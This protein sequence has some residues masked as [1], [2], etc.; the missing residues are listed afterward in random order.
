[1]QDSA[2]ERQSA[3]PDL[4]T[5]LMEPE[6]NVPERNAVLL[7]EETAA[8]G[9]QEGRNGAESQLDVTALLEEARQE[10]YNR[11]YEQSKKDAEEEH[12]RRMEEYKKNQLDPQLLQMA[13]MIESIQSA[14]TILH[15]KLEET[16]IT[17]SLA[18]AGRIVKKEITRDSQIVLPQIREALKRITGVEK[19]MLH[20][21]PKDEEL[22]RQ[23]RAQLLAAAGSVR[24]IIL[25]SDEKVSPGGC[26]LESESGNVDATIETQMKKIAEL[27]TEDRL[28]VRS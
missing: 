17:I 13:Q 22:V 23:H 6:D 25:E 1:V 24:D 2:H 16:V 15:T 26:V 21:N 5:I 19:L 10:G 3:F 9:V 28:T 8:F 27:L 14:W 12:L 4:D 18:I 20:V 11:G 7:H